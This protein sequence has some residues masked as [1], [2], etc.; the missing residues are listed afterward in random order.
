[1]K[2]P[3]LKRI[4]L[5]ANSSFRP[6]ALKTKEGS[7]DADVQAEPDEIATS[8]RAINIDSPST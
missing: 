6:K 8:L 1:M 2:R 4:E 5:C 7:K 3:T